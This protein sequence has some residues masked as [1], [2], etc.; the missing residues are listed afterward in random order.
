MRPSPRRGTKVGRTH[1]YCSIY[2]KVVLFWCVFLGGCYKLGG[3][4]GCS[5]CSG[6][7]SGGTSR[8]AGQVRGVEPGVKWEWVKDDRVVQ[9]FVAKWQAEHAVSMAGGGS[10]RVN[11]AQEMSSRERSYHHPFQHFRCIR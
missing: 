1:Q 7:R 6:K 5:S 11:T 3:L 10:R 4:V 8:A 9:T 2:T